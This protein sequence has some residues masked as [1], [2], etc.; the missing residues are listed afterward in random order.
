MDLGLG[1][2]V[3][4][5]IR[6]C[7]RPA[8]H[9]APLLAGDQQAAAHGLH[10]KAHAVLVGLKRTTLDGLFLILAIAQL[11]LFRQVNGVIL[12]YEHIAH[13]K[14]YKCHHLLVMLDVV[15]WILQ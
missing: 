7:S 11:V 10:R 6:G 12:H 13:A 8:G 4:S 15:R 14:G 2:K 3:E 1:P 9:D 5:P